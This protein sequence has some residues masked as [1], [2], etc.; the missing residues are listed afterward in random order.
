MI[1]RLLR[2]L[3]DRVADFPDVQSV[4]RESGISRRS[5]ETR[6]RKAT[7]RTILM[8]LNDARINRAC[9]LLSST[10]L[11]M[12]EIGELL[13]LSDQRLFTLVFKRC[14]GETPTAYRRR[15]RPG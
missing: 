12:R 4:V 2:L 9:T 1:R 14:T 6:F 11:S 7:G 15:V 8:E 10:D 13:G 3:R 5:L